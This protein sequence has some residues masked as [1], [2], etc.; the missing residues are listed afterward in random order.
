MYVQSLVGEPPL[1]SEGEPA[2]CVFVC[3]FL[4]VYRALPVVGDDVFTIDKYIVG[5]LVFFVL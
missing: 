3:I 5:H 1:A 4:D 2:F